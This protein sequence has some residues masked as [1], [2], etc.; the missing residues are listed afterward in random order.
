MTSKVCNFFSSFGEGAS[1]GIQT[2]DHPLRSSPQAITIPAYD[3]CMS[4]LHTSLT[5]FEDMDLKVTTDSWTWTFGLDMF[6]SRFKHQSWGHG[7]KFHD[8]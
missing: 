4:F 7:R 5:N 6:R 1:K 2:F 8:S 3:G